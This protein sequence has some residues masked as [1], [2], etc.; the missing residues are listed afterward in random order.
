ML[1]L[2][3]L[4]IPSAV[5]ATRTCFGKKAT[6]VSGKSTIK[7]TK[8]DD[9]IVSTA[10]GGANHIYGKGGN[11][12]IC[13]GPQFDWIHGGSGKDKMRGNGNFDFLEGNSGNDRLVGDTK[14]G[15]QNDAAM[16]M[17]TNRP[18]NIDLAAGVATGDGT[19][20]LSNLESAFGTVFNDTITG[21]DRTDFI[22]GLDGNDTIFG[23]GEFDFVDPGF[24]DD[25][26][27]GQA[28]DF[29]IIYFQWESNTPVEVDLAA[30][31]ATG[32]GTDAFSNFE[33]I[34]GSDGND[35]LMGDAGNNA[36]LGGGGNDSFDG[37]QGFDAATY[38]LST[39]LVT[40]NLQ[41]GSGGSVT[42]GTDTYTS[43]EALNGS[44]EYDDNLTGDNND[45]I[46]DGDGGD[47]ILVGGGGDDLFYG[48][49]GNDT[50]DGGNGNFDF[51]DY[52]G[53][54]SLD[55]NLVTGVIEG[56]TF[57][58]TV[59]GLEAVGGADKADTI[60]GG[61][62]A[63]I[64]RGWGGDDTIT[65]GGGNDEID[66]GA[67]TDT[68]IGGDGQD[69]CTFGESVSS[70]ESSV[71]VSTHPLQEAADALQAFRRNF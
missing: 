19:D 44:M 69:D 2:V 33:G 26:A 37:R 7:G 57:T 63:N 18:V 11:D 8:K 42:E 25:V 51:W 45:N 17:V 41:A 71:G 14:D 65:G 5:S 27:D 67:G 29:D 12:L 24:G 22:W 62:E 23:G 53:N 28:G 61:D 48:N 58:V 52:Y 1:A 55:A 31:T 30:G 20:R 39:A 35:V 3:A 21:S 60:T 47:D 70:C 40:A 38:W 36:F 9:V 34:Y 43:I 13:G 10:R 16:Y 6:I 68:I 66:G 56:A 49:S 46:I 54:E 32:Q 50:I 59:A 64:F 4:T 15:G